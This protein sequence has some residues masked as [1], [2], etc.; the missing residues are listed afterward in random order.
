MDSE[1]LKPL[2]PKKYLNITRLRTLEDVD[3]FLIPWFYLNKEWGWDIET[4]VHKEFFERKVR[5]TQFGTKDQQFLIDL[6]DF[7]DGD[8]ELLKEV[9]GYFGLNLDAAPKLRALMSKLKPFLCSQEYLKVGVNLG[10]EYTCFYWDFGMSTYGFYGCDMV[11]RVKYAGGHSLKDFDFYDMEHMMARYYGV[12]IDKSLQKSFD[13][14]SPLTQEQIEYACL[15]TRLPLAIRHRQ[16]HGWDRENGTHIMGIIEEG[17]WTVADIENNAISS[18]EQMHVHGENIDIPRWT[19]RVNSIVSKC[20]EV[21][22]K[23]DD[24]LIPVVGS[25]DD[26]ITEKQVEDAKKM[27][28]ALRDQLGTKDP[29]VI[30]LK[31]IASDLS[32]RRTQEKK[33][34]GDLS[35]KTAPIG[36]AMINLD[37]PGVLLNIL[38]THFKGLAGLQ[39]TDDGDLKKFEGVPI[40]DAL[41]DYREYTKQ[42]STYG[43]SWVQEWTT[44]PC[45]EEGWLSPFTHKLHARFNQLTAETGRTSSDKPNGQNLPRDPDV[46]QCFIADE[47]MVY[48]TADMSG[49][50]LRII[51]ELSDS[52]TWI[53]AFARGADLHSVGCEILFPK[54]WPEEAEPGCAYYKLNDQGKPAH[55]KCKCPKH[56]AR[57]EITK[58]INFFLAYGG[59]ATTLAERIGVT[60]EE[61]EEIMANHE[62][63][64]PEVWAYLEES[65]KQAVKYFKAFD[66]YGRRRLFRQPTK[67][68]AREKVVTDWKDKLRYPKHIAEANIQ[69]WMEENNSKK[70]P[71]GDVKFKLTHREPSEKDIAQAMRSMLN[72]IERQGKNHPIQ[73]TNATIIKKAMGCGRSPKGMPYLFHTLPLVGAKIV[74]MVH[75]EL[76]VMCPKDKG[77]IV[78]KMIG[79]A[80]REAAAEVM[81]K[82][83][84]TFEYCIAPYWDK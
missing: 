77:P 62:A 1:T 29:A 23:L 61:A 58:A 33:L 12:S 18:F 57:R 63:K 56:K 46:R 17:L 32:K 25:I 30:E 38:K 13:L 49:A 54:E 10:F 44:K 76:V 64:F 59:V 55:Q 53:D 41:R 65:G 19:A 79:K 71:T 11:E 4:T 47:G 27:W 6:L 3:K 5:T 39:S 69:K 60:V 34:I 24:L 66:M 14:S 15:D 21:I 81:K 82:V 73:S 72:G 8:A 2:D 40:I 67:E 78:A 52:P 48:V 7:V 16:L 80:F 22:K 75:D 42:I 20:D 68:E 51:A 28:K 9:Q 36:K 31:Q 45:N 74:K 70:K 83:V 37:S 43:M 26:C 50:E 84:M 35:K